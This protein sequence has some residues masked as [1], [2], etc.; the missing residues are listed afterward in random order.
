MIAYSYPPGDA[1]TLP[2]EVS[3]A[4]GIEISHGKMQFKTLIDGC[5]VPFRSLIEKY[6]NALR[7]YIIEREYDEEEFQRYFQRPK[8]LSQDLYGTPELWSWLLYINNCKSIANFTDRK[9]K[10]F[11]TDVRDAITEILTISNADM[12]A[13]RMEVYPDN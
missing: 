1:Y 9:V 3:K 5:V 7:K 8:L 6:H 10:I 2:E 4:S 12:K 11:S 13:N